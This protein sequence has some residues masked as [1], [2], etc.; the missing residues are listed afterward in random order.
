[1][2]KKRRYN[3]IPKKQRRS[4]TRT[5]RIDIPTDID[6]QWLDR[7]LGK[8]FFWSF[9]VH[10][11][12]PSD[13]TSKIRVTTHRYISPYV[14]IPRVE[15]VFPEGCEIKPVAGYNYRHTFDIRLGKPLRYDTIV[16]RVTNALEDLL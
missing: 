5:T 3:V 12:R 14:L 2:K 13:H 6:K 9:T 7:F 11:I 1:M 10:R 4:S 16:W 8:I 15:S